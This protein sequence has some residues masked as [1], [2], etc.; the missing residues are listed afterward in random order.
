MLFR[1][2]RASSVAD[3]ILEICSD[4]AKLIALKNRPQISPHWMKSQ[5]E[6]LSKPASLP[7]ESDPTIEY[8]VSQPPSTDYSLSSPHFLLSSFVDYSPPHDFP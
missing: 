3:E 7:R 1:L 2:F 5:E 8:A 6:N 4:P